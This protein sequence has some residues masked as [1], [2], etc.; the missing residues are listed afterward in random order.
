[1]ATCVAV[2]HPPVSRQDTFLCR[3]GTPVQSYCLCLMVLV[4]FKNMHTP[5]DIEDFR[6][7]T[8]TP[9]TKLAV[10]HPVR[11]AHTRFLKGPVP[12]DWVERAA[13]LPGKAL[14]IAMELWRESGCRSTLNDIPLST[15]K[16]KSLGVGRKAA[17]AGLKHL[18]AAR[19]ITVERR[20]GCLSRVTILDA[21]PVP[22]P[23]LVEPP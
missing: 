1:M 4:W 6:I 7:Q 22:V 14:H 21:E 18:E 13:N 12:W 15:N 8:S 17:Y 20:D 23:K 11:R 10:I 5:M 16:L 9:T 3:C 19:L 2:E